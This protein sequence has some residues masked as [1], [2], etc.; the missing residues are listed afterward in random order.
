[1]DI[2]MEVLLY[3]LITSYCRGGD[4]SK[5]LMCCIKSD[6][7]VVRAVIDRLKQN[8]TEENQL[9]LITVAR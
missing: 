3:V 4:I 1:M 8:L 7:L 6:Y 5:A 9:V 2:E